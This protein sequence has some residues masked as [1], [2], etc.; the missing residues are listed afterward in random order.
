MLS[1]EESAFSF[2]HERGEHM[3]CQEY[4]EKFLKDIS[5]HQFSLSN[6][7]HKIEIILQV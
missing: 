3:S 7:K 1:R 4:L 6:C 2:G 5:R